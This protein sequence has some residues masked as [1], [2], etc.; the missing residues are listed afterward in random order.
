MH[1]PVRVAK[2]QNRRTLLFFCASGDGSSVARQALQ[3]FEPGGAVRQSTCGRVDEVP[4]PSRISS[5]GSSLPMM[6][7]KSA[8]IEPIGECEEER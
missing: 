2:G 4:V 1:R 6:E 8:S 7:G 3:G 5:T